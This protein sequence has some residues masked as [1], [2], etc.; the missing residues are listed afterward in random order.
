MTEVAR[1]AGV[2]PATVSRALRNDPRITPAQRTHVQR[3]ATELGYR[4]NPLVAALMSARRSRRAESLRATIALLTHY[5]PNRAAFFRAEFGDL[6]ASI[7]ARTHAQG[8]GIAEF[9]GHAPSLSPS[10]LSEILQHRGIHGVI[11]AP[12]HSIEEQVELDWSKFC[13]V[14]IGYSLTHV[15]VSRVSHNHFTG[16]ALA[17]R[18]IRAAGYRRLGLVL[19]RR[20]HEKVEKR[21]LAAFLLDQSEHAL[22]D[23]VPPLLTEERDEAQ[24]RTW[25][26][27]HRPDAVLCLDVTLIQSWLSHLGRAARQVA[28]IGLDRRTRDR[29][30]AGIDQDYEHVGAVAADAVIGML[31]RNEQGLPPKPVSL[32]LD[33]TWIDGASL[34]L[35]D[36]PPQS[37]RDSKARAER[38]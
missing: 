25:F 12:L 36:P 23:T 5:P 33:G 34:P 19:P 21:W 8:Y 29:A 30:I 4:K 22:S 31:H 37:P 18:R 27:A 28:L 13:T 11:I 1:R 14:A 20:V 26:A 35:L 17:A 3:V 15:A 16:L 9:N 2:H 24:F 6:L 38:K 7:K 32:L 10:R